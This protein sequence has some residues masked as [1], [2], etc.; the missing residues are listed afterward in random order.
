MKPA[1]LWS[2]S[3][4]KTYKNFVLAIDIVY[5]ESFDALENMQLWKSWKSTSICNSEIQTIFF[6]RQPE[7][8]FFA[9]KDSFF[10]EKLG[11]QT[12]SEDKLW[13]SFCC[14]RPSDLSLWESDTLKCRRQLL[15][16]RKNM[17]RVLFSLTVFSLTVDCV[18]CAAHRLLSRGSQRCGW[19]KSVKLT[20]IRSK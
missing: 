4:M 13:R 19:R 6:W 18:D 11:E 17:Q 7:Q 9:D 20:K 3:Q 14:E 10:A 15:R 12:N 8:T 1:L 2:C 5:G 16:R